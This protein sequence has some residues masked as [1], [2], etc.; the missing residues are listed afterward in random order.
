MH[1]FGDRI[2]RK[3][4][5]PDHRGIGRSAIDL[6]R[7]AGVHAPLSSSQLEFQDFIPAL[8]LSKARENFSAKVEA[9]PR[10][11][12]HVQHHPES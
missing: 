9:C 7:S 11:H 12:L 6:H 10:R 4:W 5:V 1:L 2:S 8:G 3:R